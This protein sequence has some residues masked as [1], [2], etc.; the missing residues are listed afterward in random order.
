MCWKA[1]CSQ[2]GDGGG[3]SVCA[4]LAGWGLPHCL[5]SLQTHPSPLIFLCG[6]SRACQKNAL[7][8]ARQR[9]GRVCALLCACLA[10][11]FIKAG[12]PRAAE[13]RQQPLIPWPGSC[14]KPCVLLPR[15]PRAGHRCPPP[16]CPL[17]PCHGRPGS[18]RMLKMEPGG[19]SWTLGSN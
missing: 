14:G 15:Q 13:P 2:G 6:S 18:R 9:A 16:V 19:R 7:D 11:A 3:E 1:L 5:C 17:R 8:G 10:A 12:C 4:V